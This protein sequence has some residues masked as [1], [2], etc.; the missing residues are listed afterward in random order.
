MKISSRISYHRYDDFFI[1][2]DHRS[3]REYRLNADGG[4][5]IENIDHGEEPENGNNSEFIQALKDIGI[6][7]SDIA[8]SPVA[9]KITAE[10]EKSSVFDEL[11]V[12]AAKKNIPVSTIVELT[13]RCPLNCAHCYIDRSEVPQKDELKK[14]DYFKFID[15]FHTLGGIYAILTGGDPLL[16]KDF[17]SIFNYFRTKKIAVSIMS[18]GFNPDYKLL[19][20]IAKK[21]IS[22][23]QVS[24]HG[25]NSEIHDNFTGFT[26]SFDSAV[27]TL[28]TMKQ[29]GV[30]VQAAI[31][32]N[33]K[34]VNFFKDILGFLKAEKIESAINY[35][36]FPKRNGDTSPVALNIGEDELLNCLK[37]VNKEVN[38][39][40]K[41]KGPD[42]FPCNAARS[43][44]SLNPAGDVFPCLEIRKKAGNI[45]NETL[46]HIW[47]NSQTLQTIRKIKLRDLKD[48]PDCID[49]NYCNR[50]H[51]NAL[52]NG[53]EITDHSDKEC[54]M[55]KAQKKL[56][57]KIT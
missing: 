46:E 1:V 10:K 40:L 31:S 36:M 30:S 5:I 15:E 28:R 22:T 23:F 53:L 56:H 51:G 26:G 50:C 9:K 11:V 41:D 43:L 54:V 12:Y 7:E 39:R 44:F 45:K 20:R 37:I 27:S 55:A 52:K 38:S 35:E 2:L 19:E 34:N 4:T 32:V 16:H 57:D 47:K 42:D 6:I 29:L 21:G 24:I 14:E 48:C 8:K 33:K 3:G 25:H 17:E 13:Y 18:S 49:R